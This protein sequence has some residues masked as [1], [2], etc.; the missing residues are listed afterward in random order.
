MTGAIN[1]PT[2]LIWQDKWPVILIWQHVIEADT[3]ALMLTQN[4][5]VPNDLGMQGMC[6]HKQ[7]GIWEKRRHL[8]TRQ[9]DDAMCRLLVRTS[10]TRW[11]LWS[12]SHVARLFIAASSC[13]L[14]YN[15]D[16]SCAWASLCA[17]GVCACENQPW[18]IMKVTYVRGWTSHV[19]DVKLSCP[20]KRPYS[21]LEHI[22][23]W[24]NVRYMLSLQHL[25]Y[26]WLI[27]SSQLCHVTN[28]LGM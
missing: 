18:A 1:I 28:Y 23:R 16:C 3:R 26:Y 22:R 15:G 8:V 12:S 10:V 5:C 25:P 20:Q 21:Y 11:R 19:C 7:I 9:V 2:I 14:V 27:C 4:R 6:G 24:A 13:K 17:C